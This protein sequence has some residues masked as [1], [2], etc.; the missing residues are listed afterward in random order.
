MSNMTTFSSDATL[1]PHQLGQPDGLSSEKGQ[2]S[3]GQIVE[4]IDT[5]SNVVLRKDAA[6]VHDLV[7]QESQDESSL[8]QVA[9]ELS[10]WSNPQPSELSAEQKLRNK[11]VEES[12]NQG[13]N[14]V[15]R[16]QMFLVDL[17]TT[18]DPDFSAPI[19][20]IPN[21]DDAMAIKDQK[22][23]SQK[24]NSNL[25]EL[26]INLGNLLEK[27][28]SLHNS[29]MSGKLSYDQIES[30]DRDVIKIDQK[31]ADL[32]KNIADL[33]AMAVDNLVNQE[34]Q[35]ESSP[36]QL[37]TELS[38]WS[39]PPP[40]PD[41]PPPELSAEEKQLD[42][43]AEE[44]QNQG[45]NPPKLP[46]FPPPELSA[47][48]K[49]LNK[50]MAESQPLSRLQR[51]GQAIKSGMRSLG[52]GVINLA[53]PVSLA[54]IVDKNEP[55]TRAKNRKENSPI[56]Y[57]MEQ[58]LAA[59]LDKE[60]IE[61]LKRIPVNM[62][63]KIGSL[64]EEVT[65]KSVKL[66]GILKHD[67]YEKLQK[68]KGEV[69]KK[70]EDLQKRKKD[71]EGKNIL[72]RG[73]NKLMI[74]LASND[75]LR[76][77]YN[78]SA[79]A[80]GVPMAFL[81]IA[82]GGSNSKKLSIESIIDTALTTVGFAVGS[83]VKT[84]VF[85]TLLVAAV[86]AKVLKGAG[87]LAVAFGALLLSGVK[88]VTSPVTEPI[89]K[90]IKKHRAM[91]QDRATLNRLRKGYADL[92][93]EIE[94]LLAFDSI[95]PD[96]LRQ[97]NGL[98]E[99]MEGLFNTVNVAAVGAAVGIKKMAFGPKKPTGVII[100]TK[101][102]QLDREKLAANVKKRFDKVLNETRELLEEFRR[103]NDKVRS[104]TSNLSN[105]GEIPGEIETG[106]EEDINFN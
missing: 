5:S 1:T 33:E 78:I 2:F 44:S 18:D 8:V 17:S 10:E 52:Q 48:E 40:I 29:L 14:Q 34:S 63:E 57:A 84:V 71:F 75:T 85:T 47:E 74:S 3:M 87:M 76:S 26:K 23:L 46:D 20:S 42:E 89:V 51:A 94:S 98:K 69:I 95:T 43:Q 30:T 77:I 62:E 104:E 50:Q 106:D 21:Y 39:N 61:E 83:V 53:R 100:A 70:A 22:K 37:A 81:Q 28:N 72:S 67:E 86:A 49:Q 68:E 16:G 45:Q 11:Q 64:W 90:A 7:N 105:T 96:E 66:G 65:D 25:D 58:F 6:L 13:Q 27:K 102:S 80:G 15:K 91:S 97:L 59:T 19:D 73:I 32:K 101:H 4:N 60:E 93:K 24:L 82:S 41:V 55:T 35:D 56:L 31:I 103:L 79:F 99:E 36:V 9:I 38:K 54:E 92:L 88:K 12:Q